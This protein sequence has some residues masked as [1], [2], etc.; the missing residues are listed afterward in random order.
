M[1]NVI[2]VAE[3]NGVLARRTLYLG[4]L[5]DAHMRLGQPQAALGLLHNAIQIIQRTHERC[6]E[7]E[8][9]RLCGQVLI[10]LGREAEGESALQQ[11]L[12]VARKQHARHWELRAATTLA[13]HWQARHR[14]ADVSNLL[15]PVY[16][17]FTEGFDTAEL[18]AAK[19]LLHELSRT[20]KC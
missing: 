7:P 17:W 11:A 14:H 19:A 10:A 1:S 12:V 2:A 9:N 6:S 3:R 13:R 16:N 5:A 20:G 18:K 8:L 4:H 15:E